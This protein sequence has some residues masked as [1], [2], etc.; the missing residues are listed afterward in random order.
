MGT[1]FLIRICIENRSIVIG[2]FY[3]I[4]G[5]SNATQIRFDRFYIGIMP[6]SNRNAINRATVIDIHQDAIRNTC[7][8]THIRKSRNAAQILGIF[9]LPKILSRD[10]ANSKF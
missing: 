5:S 8:T 9:Q 6:V 3:L 4:A 7:N 2:T 10:T 1:Q